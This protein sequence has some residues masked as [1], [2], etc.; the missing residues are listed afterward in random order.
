[1]KTFTIGIIGGCL[2]AAGAARAADMA[3]SDDYLHV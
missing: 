3:S 1:M 2:L